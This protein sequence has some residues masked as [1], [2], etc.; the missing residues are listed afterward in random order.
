M[1]IFVGYLLA[2]I[3]ASPSLQAI[4]YVFVF[5]HV[6]A[7]IVWTYSASYRIMQ[8][9][10]C[11]LQ[12]NEFSTPLLSL[13][14]LMLTAGYTSGD[15]ALS[16]VNI[17]FFASF[18]MIRVVPMPSI[19]WNWFYRDFGIVEKAT[20]RG[21]ALVVSAFVVVHVGLQGSWFMKMCRKLVGMMKGTN[22]K[23]RQE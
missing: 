19:I 7:S 22:S 17:V 18:G 1:G 6:A 12:F 9:L 4:G 11:F 16:I 10:A 3:I 15:K 13:R 8:L 20:G 21:A 23:G 2:D 14:H 5:H